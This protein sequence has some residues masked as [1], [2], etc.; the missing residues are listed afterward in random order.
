[1]VP[2]ILLAYMQGTLDSNNPVIIEGAEA[3]IR[4]GSALLNAGD[5]DADGHEGKYIG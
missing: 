2:S 3:N 4:F 5:L 1:M